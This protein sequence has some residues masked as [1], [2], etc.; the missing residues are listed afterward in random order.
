MAFEKIGEFNK[1]VSDLPD[2][3]NSIY[4]AAELKEYFDSAPT[5][6]KNGLNNL[7][8]S[9]LSTTVGDSGADNLGIQPIEG[10]EGTKI[11]DMLK[12]LRDIDE[13][14]YNSLLVQLQGLT[15]GQIPIGS[16]TEDRLAFDPATQPEF[17]VHLQNE[18]IHKT[19]SQ[20]RSD[21][22]KPFIVEVR[23]TDPVTPEVGRIWY[24]SDL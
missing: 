12:A 10:I 5:Q 11:P 8:D 7:V 20:V 16:I 18:E 17:N 15:L 23:T 14:N 13:D 24:R 9:L 19:S 21:A 4:T 2:K 6:V 22:A 1:K 3:P